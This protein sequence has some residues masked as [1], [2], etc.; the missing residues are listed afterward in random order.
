MA[1]LFL[2]VQ[3]DDS[4]G[5]DD[6]GQVRSDTFAE[7]TRSIFVSRQDNEVTVCLLPYPAREKFFPPT[8]SCET[9]AYSPTLES[10]S[11]CVLLC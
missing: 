5:D 10:I 9:A 1:G 6:A 3:P 7:P 4:W 2:F 11:T 8:G